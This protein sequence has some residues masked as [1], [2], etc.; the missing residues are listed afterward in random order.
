MKPRAGAKEIPCCECGHSIEEHAG[1][2]QS[3]ISCP[4]AAFEAGE[5]ELTVP[6]VPIVPKPKRRK[7]KGAGR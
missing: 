6:I 1:C 7:R 2:G 3:C 5:P 4:C